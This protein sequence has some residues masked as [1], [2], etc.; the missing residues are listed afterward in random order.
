MTDDSV[1]ARFALGDPHAVRELYERHSSALYGAAMR[2][3][4][5]RTLAQDAVQ[6]AFL[7]AWRA[8]DQVDTSRDIAPWLFTILRNVAIDIYRGERR[9]SSVE[10]DESNGELDVRLER[11]WAVHEVRLALANLSVDEQRA[12][13]AVYFEGLTHEQAAERLDVPLGTVKSRITRAVR[14][15]RRLLSHLQEVSR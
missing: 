9:H 15:L 11:M 2:F 5:D 4:G 13:A 3:L 1:E 10:L 8:A 12:L 6:Q 7:K 14:N